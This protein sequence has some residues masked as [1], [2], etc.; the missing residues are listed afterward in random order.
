M[1]TLLYSSS[2]PATLDANWSFNLCLPLQHNHRC[3]AANSIYHPSLL[4]FPLLVSTRTL[5]HAQQER[6]IQNLTLTF[7]PPFTHDTGWCI[8]SALI[9][10]IRLRDPVFLAGVSY[11]YQVNTKKINVSL[12]HGTIKLYCCIRTVLS[13][14]RRSI[15]Y[16]Y[17]EYKDYQKSPSPSIKDIIACLA[18]VGLL[19]NCVQY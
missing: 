9:R 5:L 14:N 11:F 13:Q 7:T 15:L 8:Y 17:A 3:W 1:L 12:I 2:F 4:V 19:R 16:T 6:Q 10:F 18:V